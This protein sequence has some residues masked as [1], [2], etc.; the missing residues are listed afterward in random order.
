[1][2]LSNILAHRAFACACT[3][4]HVDFHCTCLVFKS[5]KLCMCAFLGLIFGALW[6]LPV[7]AILLNTETLLLLIGQ[8]QHV[9]SMA[10]EF[11]QLFCPGVLA[12]C[13]LFMIMRYL[14]CQ[15]R[16]FSDTSLRALPWVH[17]LCRIFSCRR[18]IPCAC[19]LVETYVHVF[20]AYRCT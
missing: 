13:W 2:Y 3:Y 15:V 17:R 1:M 9:A 5:I 19:T 4:M 7:V 11:T 20:A 10:Q 16:R 6:S 12:Y 18:R 14:L 8:E